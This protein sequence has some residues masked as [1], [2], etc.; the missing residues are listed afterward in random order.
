LKDLGFQSK[1]DY[2][3]TGS[4]NVINDKLNIRITIF[5]TKGREIRIVD[6]VSDE[7]GVQLQKTPDIIS[8]SIK[9]NVEYLHRANHD[10]LNKSKF[11]TLY[12]PFSI[13]TM[14]VDSGYTNI[15]G[16]WS[17]LYNDTLYLAPFI[18]FDLVYDFSLSFK[19]NYINSDSEDKETASYS[20]IRILSS[21]MSIG[22]NYKFLENFGIALSAGGGVTKTTIIIEPA[23]PFSESLSEKD[24]IDPNIDISSYF[25]YNLSAITFRAGVHYKR[26]FFKDEPMDTGTVF[27]GAGIHF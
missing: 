14:G 3:I 17:K 13:I 25:V 1:S 4:F 19:F 9:E 10:R 20:Q 6:H 18:D 15:L 2:I 8:D 27:A 7:L 12:K 16:D 23:G 21:S 5:D 26:I 24:S 11:I 22:Y